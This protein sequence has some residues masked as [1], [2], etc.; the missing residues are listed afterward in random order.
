MSSSS[1]FLA[2]L[3]KERNSLA[4]IFL[5]FVPGASKTS[6]GTCNFS[7]GNTPHRQKNRREQFLFIK[8]FQ[9]VGNP[10]LDP[11]STSRS[12]GRWCAAH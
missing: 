2:N 4:K 5:F 8:T 6:C 7:R 9:V 11:G 12:V 3:R 10:L 1:E